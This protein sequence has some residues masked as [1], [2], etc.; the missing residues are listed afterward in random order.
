VK[1]YI[2][3]THP[4]AVAKAK[5]IDKILKEVSLRWFLLLPVGRAEKSILA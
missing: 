3:Q 1:D 4:V 5:E 2:K